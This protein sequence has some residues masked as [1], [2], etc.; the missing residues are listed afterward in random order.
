MSEQQDLKV[1]LPHEVISLIK[2][3]LPS[4]SY[5][6][7]YLVK[8]ISTKSWKETVMIFNA[9]A[10]LAEALWHHPDVELSFRRVKIKLKTHE[11]NGITDRDF[12]LAGHIEDLLRVKKVL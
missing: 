5:E 10:Y 12:E 9:V 11:L 6:E 8:E 2:E 7:G 4:W 3:K 1:Y